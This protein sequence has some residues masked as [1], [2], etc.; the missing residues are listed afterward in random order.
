MFV[1]QET[2]DGLNEAEVAKSDPVLNIDWIYEF[3]APKYFDFTRE[4]TDAEVMAAE[5]W[6]EFA[7]PYE[8][9]RTCSCFSN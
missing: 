3:S 5:R 2:M 4:E 7:I 1:I 9:S 6:F 8:N